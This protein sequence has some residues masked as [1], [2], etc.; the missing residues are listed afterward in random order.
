MGIGIGVLIKTRWGAETA[1]AVLVMGGWPLQQPG[2]P[3]VG[4]WDC[5][6]LDYAWVGE[7][8]HRVSI[9]MGCRCLFY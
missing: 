1:T 8:Q 7:A 9:T 2:N 4:S 6:V 3:P 5:L